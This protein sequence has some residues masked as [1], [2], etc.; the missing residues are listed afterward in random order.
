M[1]M[2]VERF[3]KIKSNIDKIKLVK[4]VNIIAVSKT[5]PLS[6]VQPLI[7]YGHIHFGENQ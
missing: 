6:H 5:F 2:I 3:N 4:P 7:N 1:S